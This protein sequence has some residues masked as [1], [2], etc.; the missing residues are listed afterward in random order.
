MNI[1]S[2]TK[3]LAAL[4]FMYLLAGTAIALFMWFLRKEFFRHT[5]YPIRFNRNN[6]M[7]YVF[8]LDGTVL[9]VPW[10]E[11]FFT[12]CPAQMRGVWE[13]RGHVLAEDQNTV[14]ETFVLS[15]YG[16]LS[17]TELACTGTKIEESDHVR[18][19]WEFGGVTWKKAPKA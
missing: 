18:R 7:V 13:V 6:R 15:Y 9:A 16:Q 5:H 11:V 17:K 12:L 4:G 8:R 1:E 19:H 3:E 14:K 10:D 2:L